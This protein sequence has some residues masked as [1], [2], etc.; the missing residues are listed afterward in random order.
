MQAI[1]QAILAHLLLHYSHREPLPTDV[2]RKLSSSNTG[3]SLAQSTLTSTSAEGWSTNDWTNNTH[4]Y[5]NQYS[6]TSLKVFFT[7]VGVLNN[8]YLHLTE[9]NVI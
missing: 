1:R 4:T 5:F 6:Y 3:R 2:S 7:T 8:S 9:S